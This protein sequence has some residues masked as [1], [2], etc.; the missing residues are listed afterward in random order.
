[1]VGKREGIRRCLEGCIRKAEKE[2][3]EQ[4]KNLLKGV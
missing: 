4:K 1:M 3:D 2:G